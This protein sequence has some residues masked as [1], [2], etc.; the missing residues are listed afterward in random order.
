MGR[1]SDDFM[2]L[3]TDTAAMDT[4]M[5]CV[6]WWLPISVQKKAVGS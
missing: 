1:Y 4:E 3:E 6:I 5:S 2:P